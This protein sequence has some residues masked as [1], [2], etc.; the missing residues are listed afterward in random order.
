[1]PALNV[2]VDRELAEQVRRLEVPVSAT[3]QAALRRRVRVAE[4][5]LAVAAPSAATVSRDA[6][7]DGP[8]GWS[9]S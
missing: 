9:V 7:R 5:R 4:R 1:M 3:C 2:Y 8:G 6:R